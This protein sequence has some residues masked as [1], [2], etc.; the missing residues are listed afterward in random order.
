MVWSRLVCLLLSLSS[1]SI[2]SCFLPPVLLC[3]PYLTLLYNSWAFLPYFECQLVAEGSNT[4]TLK[5]FGLCCEPT[6]R[7]LSSPTDGANTGIHLAF[8]EM[9]GGRVGSN[10]FQTPSLDVFISTQH[11]TQPSLSSLGVMRLDVWMHIPRTEELSSSQMVSLEG[12]Q[13]MNMTFD[14]NILK[15]RELASTPH[16]TVAWRIENKW[17][18][19]EKKKNVEGRGELKKPLERDVKRRPTKSSWPI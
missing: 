13:A 1:S 14:F 2:L 15:G 8:T 10:W 16:D 12:E 19:A 18:D 17:L 9:D 11:V 4:S 6:Q 7:A 3:E 5:V